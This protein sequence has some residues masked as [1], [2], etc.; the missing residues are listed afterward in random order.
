[1]STDPLIVNRYI[2]HLTP[3]NISRLY[4]PLQGEVGTSYIFQVYTE[5]LIILKR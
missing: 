4:R 2:E 1:M 5:P 3:Q